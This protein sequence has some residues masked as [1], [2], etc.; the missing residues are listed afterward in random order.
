LAYSPCA[1]NK[2]ANLSAFTTGTL[3]A[4]HLIAA[5]LYNIRRQFQ[6]HLYNIRR[7]FQL[8]NGHPCQSTEIQTEDAHTLL[9]IKGMYSN[10]YTP[11]QVAQAKAR[12]ILCMSFANFLKPLASAL[13]HKDINHNHPFSQDILPSTG[14]TRA[15]FKI[16]RY[17]LK[18]NLCLP[19]SFI[20]HHSALNAMSLFWLRTQSHRAIPTHTYHFEDNMRNLYGDRVCTRCTTNTLDCETHAILECAFSKHLA[21]PLIHKLRSLLSKAGQPSRDS[22]RHNKSQSF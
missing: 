12:N 3:S 4:T 17:S 16:M 1:Y 19:S 9:A 20:T 7:Q 14:R 13:W 5:H 10:P 6:A 22:L 11:S 15:Y 8:S 21:F 2:H 18:T